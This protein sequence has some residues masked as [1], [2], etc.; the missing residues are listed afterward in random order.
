MVLKGSFANEW[1]AVE[2]SFHCMFSII[3]IKQVT[4]RISRLIVQQQKQHLQKN[5]D[6]DS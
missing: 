3:L 1:I 5:G 4:K 2:Y 6:H